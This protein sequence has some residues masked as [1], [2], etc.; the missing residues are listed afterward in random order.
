MTKT[1]REGGGELPGPVGWRIIVRTDGKIELRFPRS[2]PITA[3][4]LVEYGWLRGLYLLADKDDRQIGLGVE[5]EDV[6]KRFFSEVAP[7][8]LDEV[9]EIVKDLKAKVK[10][11]GSDCEWR[12]PKK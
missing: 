12:E 4:T 1:S 7:K 5:D 3:R 11:E 10:A 6:L 2:F 8:R 9:M